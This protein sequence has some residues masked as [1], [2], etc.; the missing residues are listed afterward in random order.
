MSVCVVSLLYGFI[1]LN[2]HWHS[3]C[4]H[5]RVLV[6]GSQLALGHPVV[7]KSVYH[8]SFSLLS[9]QLSEAYCLLASLPPCR[10]HNASSTI[11]QAS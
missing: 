4:L 11:T 3:L 9:S 2:M 10:H 6:C 7:F 1:C 5:I 8:L